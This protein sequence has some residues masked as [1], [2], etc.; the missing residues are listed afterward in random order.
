M[1]PYLSFGLLTCDSKAV[2]TLFN[3]VLGQIRSLVQRQ[4]D[5]IKSKEKKLPKVFPSSSLD[6]TEPNRMQCI[7]L[8]GGFGRCSYLYASLK[9]V[10]GPKGIDVLQTAGEEP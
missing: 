1:I 3:P 4:I 9:E 2:E 5:Q 8:V 10:F 7:M 6:R